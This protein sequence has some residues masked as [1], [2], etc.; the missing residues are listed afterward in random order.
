MSK[1]LYIDYENVQKVNLSRIAQLDFKIW[2]FTGVSQSR[3]PI[4]LVKSTQAFGSNLKWVSIDGN[5]PNAL[6]FHI[7]YYLGLHTAENA[8]DEY[9]ILSKDKGFDPLI[10]HLVNK[11][12]KCRRINSISEVESSART[13]AKVKKAIDTDRA[14]A[15]IVENLFKIEESRRPRN[16][17]TLRGHIKTLIGKSQTEERI[18]QIISQLFAA[19]LV[20]DAGR[21]LTYHL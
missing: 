2:V 5:G 11:K 9:F 4:E 1:V 8:K 13:P 17:K 21:G 14:Y 12:I 20:V 15:K 16:R 19:N 6:D 7:A 3:I 10:K 18:D